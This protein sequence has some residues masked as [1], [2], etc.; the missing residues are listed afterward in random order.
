MEIKKKMCI[1]LNLFINIIMFQ[2]SALDNNLCNITGS[3]CFSQ[4][5]SAIMDFLT[6]VNAEEMLDKN[7][8]QEDFL[9]RV[10]HLSGEDITNTSST[11]L[12]F[13]MKVCGWSF[14]FNYWIFYFRKSMNIELG[15]DST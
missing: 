5:T 1:N 10:K 14:G 15:T 8:D 11:R 2:K 12:N 3:L 6:T 7:D 9:A 13:G 4:I